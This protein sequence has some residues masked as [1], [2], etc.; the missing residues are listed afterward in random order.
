M[1]TTNND[2]M[3]RV[4]KKKAIMKTKTLLTSLLLTGVSIMTMAQSKDKA[5]FIE[6]KSG[7]YQ[8]TILKGIKDFDVEKKEIKKHKV[9]KIDLSASTLP[10][11]PDK[12]IKV[13]HN[14]PVS[15]GN[16]ATCWCFSTTSYYESEI[17][18]ISGKEVKLSEM[19]TVYWEYL[20][21][22][23]NFVAT[24]GEIVLGEGSQTMSVAKMM[25]QHGLVRI[26]DYT[27]LK[28]GQ[29][30]HT[31]EKMFEEI[32]KYL[33]GVKERNE[34]NEEL[35]VSTVKE[36]LE[37]HMGTVPEKIK[38]DG[39]EISPMD[40][41]K[42]QLK[43]NPD[44]YVDFM[45]LMNAPYYENSLY[46]VPDNWYRSKDFKNVPLDDFMGLIKNALTKGHSISIGGDVSEAGFESWKQVAIIP[47][48]DIPS[49]Y[50]D[51]NA[52]AFRFLNQ[53]TTDD[54]AMHMVGFQEVDGK[55]WYLVKDSGAG[56]RNCGE[57]CKEF[58]YYFM[59]E[60][61]IKLKMMTMTIHKDVAKDVLAKM[62]K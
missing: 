13:W 10:T 33:K 21:R 20:E 57:T 26:E 54:H 52:R 3:H 46:D 32:E 51:E 49:D 50:I 29:T 62:K 31:H 53:S 61:Y 58:G 23:K 59:H 34:W 14:K 55:T 47:T 11:D 4:S 18:R 38:V 15:Q 19:F 40:Y 24:R 7:Y 42:T 8:N 28:A 39:K 9:F 60:D 48:F 22:A 43:L 1:K 37:F 27:G 41:M 12:Y 36:I 2:A 44:D 30:V 16:T 25:K 45:S 35:V 5:T 6:T 17:K 56:S